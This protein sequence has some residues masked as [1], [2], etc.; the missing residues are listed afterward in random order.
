MPKSNQSKLITL[1]FAAAA[2]ALLVAGALFL[3]SKAT[4]AESSANA[5]AAVLPDTVVGVAWSTS[6]DD[7][8]KLAE[9][10]KVTSSALDSMGAN[11]S[12]AV[13]LLGFDPLDAK[14]LAELGVDTAGTPAVALAP[15][16]KSAGLVV[17]YLPIR[18][19]QSG[20]DMVVK[21]AEKFGDKAPLVEKAE[22]KGRT[23]AWVY[24]RKVDHEA[25]WGSAC[26]HAIKILEDSGNIPEEQFKREMK[27]EISRECLR[28]FTKMSVDEADQ[29][30]RCIIAKSRMEDLEYCMKEAKDG[31][32][33]D[34]AAGSA[35]TQKSL[36][37]AMVDVDGGLLFIAPV[38]YRNR[39][40]EEI[41][42][43]LRG[44]VAKVLDPSVPRLADLDGYGE[45]V[46]GSG[47]VLLGGYANPIGLREMMAGE[48][49]LAPVVA[50]LT[51]VAGFGAYVKEE[52]NSLVVVVQT[53][54]TSKEPKQFLRK[55]DQ[56]VLSLVPGEPLVG[57][58]LAID[59]ELM[60]RE[61]ERGIALEPKAWREYVEGKQEIQ[62]ALKLPGV[63]IHQI[64]D[65]EFGVFVGDLAPSPE[66]IVKSIVAFAGIKDAEKV[67]AALDAAVTL[68]RGELVAEKVG[69][70]P[71]WRFSADGLTM[72][73][74]IH[75]NRLWF[76]GDWSVLSKIEKGE[77]GGLF[78]GERSKVLAAVMGEDYGL[79][80]YSDLKKPLSLVQAM[81]GRRDKEMLAT[82]WPALS[83]FDYVTYSGAQD[84]RV[85]MARAELHLDGQSFREVAVEAVGGQFLKA[86]ET[87]GR[88]AKTAE[89]IDQLDKIYKG[90]AVYYT[91]PRVN[92]M[93]ERLDC[94]F[95]DPVGLTPAPSCCQDQGGADRDGDGRC[96]VDPTVWDAPTWSS[97]SFQMNDPH[98]CVYS[99]DTNGLS[100]SEA[101]FTANAHCDLDCDGV[102]STFQRYGKGESSY[103]DCTVSSHAA[104]YVE[105]ETE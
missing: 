100:G 97:L 87:Y 28:E 5:L 81:A 66:F 70:D 35:P 19:G 29:A 30:A 25:L 7:A 61:L 85:S 13:A 11:Y 75:D 21:V 68:S 36:R 79:A 62:E 24:R 20:I 55:R 90:A 17:V 39:H 71:G 78:S 37:G 51:E 15:A 64:W 31:G 49:D 59:S 103:G 94:Q 101:Q 48:K 91:T 50:A 4:V 89:V 92:R 52:G 67:K 56:A 95:P 83:K 74:L 98:Y 40:K 12:R 38:D 93:G 102:R 88:K 23:V 1:A 86:A 3:V 10:M 9:T 80:S 43:E 26:D 8:L 18:A 73:V 54:A 82:V 22:E 46:A 14:A 63:E 42:T 84:G 99:F 27:D 105:N 32:L 104:M 96:D 44:F 65:G 6:I 58:H 47:D 41:E 77:K 72:G 57:L 76:A 45:S 34:F 60:M 69:E 2:I 33:S 16:P 53:V